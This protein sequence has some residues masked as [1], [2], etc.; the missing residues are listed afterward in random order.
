MGLHQTLI[1]I[2]ELALSEPGRKPVGPV[3]MDKNN[4]FTKDMLE[5]FI[6]VPEGLYDVVNDIIYSITSLT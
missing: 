3:E 4:P 1:N 2:N 5:Y 6:V